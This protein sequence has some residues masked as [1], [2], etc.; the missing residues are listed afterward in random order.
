[1]NLLEIKLDKNS[2]MHDLRVMDYDYEDAENELQDHIK[3]F[4]SLPNVLN[5][6]RIVYVDSPN[7]L[8]L[9]IPG[10]HY[11][12]DKEELLLNH[13]YSTGYGDLKF[14]ITV[15]AKKSLIDAQLT[16]SNNILYPNEKE[17]TLK[18]KGKGSKIISV[19]EIN[20]NNINESEDKKT[21]DNVKNL[22]VDLINKEGVEKTMDITGLNVLDLFERIGNFKFDSELSGLV[23]YLLFK[24][25][26]LPKN[27]NNFT[28]NWDYFDGVLYW[29]YKNEIETSE[30]MCTPFWDLLNGTPIHMTY[31]TYI[32]IEGD[33][34][35]V[36]LGNDEK[37]IFIE[38]EFTFNNIQDLITWFKEFYI[39]TCYYYLSKFLDEVRE[40]NN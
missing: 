12:T 32:D 37:Y 39:P 21:H 9:K 14:L 24:E 38:N 25:G 5:L 19:E 7:E 20:D 1:M 15:E 28:L 2:L 8:N 3:W 30:S 17:I 6:Y 26:K 18:N 31:Y 34:N 22:L 27:V 13:T 10:S 35:E 23:L 33:T 16:I 4:E 40:E 11:S 36:E 29:Q